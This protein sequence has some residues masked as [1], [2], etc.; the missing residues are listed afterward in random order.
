MGHLESGDVSSAAI[1]ARVE[2]EAEAEGGDEEEVAAAE[3][4][5]LFFLL[6]P[7]P[8]LS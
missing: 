1:T 6:L 4:L 5:L 2:A 8:P 7:R 3:V